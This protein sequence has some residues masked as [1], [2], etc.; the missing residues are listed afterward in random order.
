MFS[1]KTKNAG[2]DSH[3][4]EE[5]TSRQVNL[6]HNSKISLD[7]MGTYSGILPCADCM[8]IQTKLVLK[9][10][11]TLEIT[12]IYLGKEHEEVNFETIQLP[13]EWEEDGN[14]I[15]FMQ[16]G[17]KQYYK[18]EEN[19]LRFL[20]SDKQ[21][22]RGELEQNYLLKKGENTVLNKYWRATEIMGLK[23]ET[24]KEMKREAHLI[25]HLNGTFS[26]TGGCNSFFGNFQIERKNWINFQEIG[27]TEMECAFKS[28]DEELLEALN[29]AQQFN[30]IGEDTLEL[31]VGK[32]AALAK[33]ETVYLR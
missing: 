32:R 24:S 4:K 11:E 15:S 1:C 26:G 21:I 10:D 3:E 17:Q 12:S 9:G 2:I 29:Q 16:Y 20:D 19:Q 6:E 30:L 23:V 8:G 5:T 27:M 33:F 22:I 13:F 14:S 25:F 31:I 18:V 28:Y 7:W